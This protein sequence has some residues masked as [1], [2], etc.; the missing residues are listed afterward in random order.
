MTQD[1][2]FTL[3]RFTIVA[4]NIPAARPIKTLG[5]DL[6]ESKDRYKFLG[7][8]NGSLARLSRCSDKAK[9]TVTADL[10]FIP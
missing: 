1:K 3:A 7:L 10:V 5:G 6:H 8:A 9:I 4:L 2:L